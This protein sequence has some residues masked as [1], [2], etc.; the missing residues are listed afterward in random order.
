[1][2]GGGVVM[3]EA[4]QYVNLSGSR[5]AS[6]ALAAIEELYERDST[7][8]YTIAIA[9]LG[10]ETRA[11]DVVTESFLD[12]WR[13]ALKNGPSV[14]PPQESLVRVVRRR[15]IDRMCAHAG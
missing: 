11:L 1:M 8:A 3:V 15:C 2:P 9:L 6:K 7:V 5:Q 13:G 10:D 12:V 14:I 4:K